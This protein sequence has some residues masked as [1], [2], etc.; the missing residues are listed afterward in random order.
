[1]V[2]DSDVI[3][4]LLQLNYEEKLYKELYEQKPDAY[5]IPIREWDDLRNR[6]PMDIPLKPYSIVG[7]YLTEQEFFPEDGIEVNCF[8][9]ARYCPPFLHQ[10]EFIKIVYVRKGSLTFYFNGKRYEM[11]EGQFCIVAPGT[12]Q[13]VFSHHDEDIVLNVLLMASTFT[14][15]FSSLLSEQTVLSDYFWKM[16]YSKYQKQILIFHNKKNCVLDRMVERLYYEINVEEHTSNLIVKS[17]VMIFL[18]EALREH[19]NTV[20]ALVDDE[21]PTYQIP[22]ILRDIRDNI[23][24]I[25]LEDLAEKWNM[26]ENRMNHYLKIEVG[27][28][29]HYILMDLRMNKA[30][31]YLVYTKESIEKIMEL[32]GFNDSTYFYKNFRQRYGVT[33]QKYR[34]IGEVKGIIPY[35]T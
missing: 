11:K 21:K 33:P 35:L 15:A 26:S 8:K 2:G 12:E 1:M 28:S 24:S 16:M 19:G 14:N 30:A 17:Y 25:T 7:R 13:A 6:F 32:S 4:M 27:Y 29:F 9:N 5:E 20:K 22:K 31:E 34:E 3:S 10:L 23:T 18:V